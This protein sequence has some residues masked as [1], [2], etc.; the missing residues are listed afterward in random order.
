MPV[1]NLLIA[2][3]TGLNWHCFK[4]SYLTDSV[5]WGI[6]VLAFLLWVRENVDVTFV[7]VNNEA[8]ARTSLTGLALEFPE[9]QMVAWKPHRDMTTPRSHWTCPK[10][11]CDITCKTPMLYSLVFVL[12]VSLPPG[13][14]QHHGSAVTDGV[15]HYNPSV[16]SSFYPTSNCSY[17]TTHVICTHSIRRIG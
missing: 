11:W 3:I 2:H 4:V 8:R 13:K 10:K 1:V 7:S 14:K 17:T 9:S 6:C 15:I 16:Y 12:T 5:F